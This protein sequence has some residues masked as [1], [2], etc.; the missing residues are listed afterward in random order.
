MPAVSS[1]VWEAV[2]WHQPVARA[3]PF[4]EDF[5]ARRGHRRVVCMMFRV[6]GQCSRNGGMAMQSNHDNIAPFLW[7][8]LAA[9]L[10]RSC[11]R[12]GCGFGG[13]RRGITRIM[14]SQ[15]GPFA[16]GLDEQFGHPRVASDA[17]CRHHWFDLAHTF[18]LRKQ[19][20]SWHCATH[21]V[22]GHGFWQVLGW[23]ASYWRPRSRYATSVGLFFACRHLMPQPR[24][25]ENW[26]RM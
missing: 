14:M 26:S 8:R 4:G 25:K 17:V 19:R 16:S 11:S 1:Q 2:V 5:A 3:R 9:V 7:A 21:S 23:C 22:V 24:V 6:R 12:K 10:S 20:T 13:G 18:E 15:G